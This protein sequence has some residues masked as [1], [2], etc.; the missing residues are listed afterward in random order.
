LNG[1]QLKAYSSAEGCRQIITGVS[2]KGS[3]TK[4]KY[5]IE[6]RRVQPVQPKSKSAKEELL[7]LFENVIK[8][9]S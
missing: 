4:I 8:H 6:R 2:E 9:V 5:W 3:E 1:L 7:E